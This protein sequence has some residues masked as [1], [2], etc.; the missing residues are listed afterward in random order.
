LIDKP[1]V[2]TPTDLEAYIETRGLLLEPYEAWMPGEIALTYEELTNA[3]SKALFGADEYRKDRERLRRI[4]HRYEDAN[5]TERVLRLAQ[6]LLK[7]EPCNH[8]PA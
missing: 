4:S 5:S 8:K 3:I 6:G 7:G 2:L 1:I